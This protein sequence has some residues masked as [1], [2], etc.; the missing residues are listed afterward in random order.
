MQC[1]H[2][3]ETASWRTDRI[4]PYVCPNGHESELSDELPM[5]G[6]EPK[7]K[8]VTRDELVEFLDGAEDMLTREEVREAILA[9]W[10]IAMPTHNDSKVYVAAWE[11]LQ[12][13][14]K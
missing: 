3:D 10:D 5:Y 13:L 1:P 6:P 8:P 9:A 11:R 7:P 2:C 4:G 12:E 14:T